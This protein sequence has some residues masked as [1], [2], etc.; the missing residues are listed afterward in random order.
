MHAQAPQPDR[1]H[2]PAQVPPLAKRGR[3]AQGR[4]VASSMPNTERPERANL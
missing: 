1:N 3:Q 2:A 4:A